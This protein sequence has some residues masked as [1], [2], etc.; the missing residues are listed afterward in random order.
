MRFQQYAGPTHELPVKDEEEKKFTGRCRLFVGNVSH[1]IQ[2][3][4]FKKMFEPFGEVSEVYVNGAKGFGFIK[5]DTRANAENA[6]T[7]LD[8]TVLKGHTIR[9]RFASHGAALRIK[10]LSPMVSNELLEYAFSMFG[11]IERAVVAVDDRGRPTGEGVVEFARK[12]KATLALK[13]CQEECF[14]ITN[15]PRPVI[16]EPQD[17]R[18]DDDGLPE[19]ILPRNS[20]QFFKERDAGPRFAMRNSFEYEFGQRWK[21]LYDLEKQKRDTLERE[22]QEDRER[23]EEQMEFSIYE[24][25]TNILREKLRQREEDANALLREREMRMREQEMIREEQRRQQE[26]ILRRRQELITAAGNRKPGGDDVRRR[27]EDNLMMQASHL[28][29]LLDQQEAAMRNM[30]GGGVAPNALAAGIDPTNG[31]IAGFDAAVAAK[32]G[33]MGG[34]AAG[35]PGGPRPSRFDQTNQGP[36]GPGGP[37]GPAGMNRGGMGGPGGP[38]GPPMGGPMGGERGGMPRRDMEFHGR[39][40]YPGDMKRRRF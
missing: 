24:A 30:Q 37:S 4:E 25:E 22:I 10:N 14:L 31:N 7:S 21:E 13:R 11:E 2:E 35:G 5:M 29:T 3:E 9:V 16:V 26:E 27:Q 6:R 33:G 12:N 18:D 34:P 32:P 19:K 15:S 17:Q 38:G 23:L 8:C 36:M 39:E 1:E 40:D 28:N 20:P